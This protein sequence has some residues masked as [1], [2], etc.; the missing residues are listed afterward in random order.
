MRVAAGV[1]CLA[2]L[3]RVLSADVELAGPFTNHM[4]LQRERRVPVWGW[5]EPGE[6]VTM[7]SWA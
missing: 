4:V 6:K 3:A 7:A 5:A 1:L 2:W